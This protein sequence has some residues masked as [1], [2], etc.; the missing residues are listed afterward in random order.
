MPII[1]KL[2][3]VKINAVVDTDLANAINASR[4]YGAATALSSDEQLL[5]GDLADVIVIASPHKFHSEQL[6]RALSKG[7]AVFVEK[8][9]VTDFDQFKKVMSFLR[10]H[11]H[12]PF[13]VDYNRPF[14]PFMQK[15]KQVIAKRTTPLVVHYRMNAGYI[16]KDHWIQTDLGAGQIIGQACHLFDLFCFLTDARPVSVSVET[17]RSHRDDLFTTDNFS[18]QVAFADGSLCTLLF[19]A[20]GHSAV[21]KERMELFYDGK[22]IVMDDFL[23]LQGHGLPLSFNE[24][25]STMDKGH[26]TLIT[27][28]F[29]AVK[30]KKEMPISLDRLA[31]V[32]E[33]TLIIDQLACQG[34]GVKELSK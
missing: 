28:F 29:D 17:I 6:L 2:P 8:P 20:L 31:T 34:G 21:G 25:R 1:S 11:P 19:T 15:I 27:K 30:N 22:T 10:E 14:S 12:I 18:A 24:K 23:T 13:T 16:P 7:K 32:A 3:A 9:M 4:T 33:L 5:A 26:A